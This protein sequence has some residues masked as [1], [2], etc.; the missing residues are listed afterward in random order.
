MSVAL[1]VDALSVS[2]DGVK[3]VRRIS[4]QVHTGELVALIGSN[5]AGKSSTLGAIMGLVPT[6]CRSI[7][8]CGQEV[9]ALGTHLRVRQGISLVPE[10]RGVLTRMTVLENLQLGALPI[11]TDTTS[12][13]D[14]LEKMFGYFPRLKERISQMAGTMSGGEQQMLALARALMCRP[15]VLLLDEPSM[16]LSPI[17]VD[18]IFSVIKKVSDSGVTILLVEQNASLALEISNRAYVMSSGVVTLTG[19]SN[20]MAADPRVQESYLGR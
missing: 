9:S 2:Y 18:S 11:N 7:Q 17:M 16:G 4:V 5:G 14:D 20:H 13:Q 3:A 19:A 12:R 10:G 1:Q 6:Q 8:V 15:K